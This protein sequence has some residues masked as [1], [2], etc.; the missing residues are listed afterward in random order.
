MSTRAW[1]AFNFLRHWVNKLTDKDFRR[2]MG[3]LDPKV[4]EQLALNRKAY[5]QGPRL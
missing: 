5:Q 2:C 1:C 4:Q 3:D